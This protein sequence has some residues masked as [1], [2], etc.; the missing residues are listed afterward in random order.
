MPTDVAKLTW[1]ELRELGDAETRIP[2][3]A[4]VL[5]LFAD[6]ASTLLIDMDEAHPAE[7]A[8]RVVAGSGAKVAWCGHLDGMRTIR[9]LDPAARIWMPWDVPGSP[10]AADIAALSPEYVNMEYLTATH[11][12]VED[13]HALGCSVAVWTVDDPLTMR[14]VREM[15][16]DAVTTNQLRLLRQVSTQEQSEGRPPG[17]GTQPE[18]NLD[19]VL[20]IARDLGQWVIDFARSSDPGQI[21]TKKDP[22]DLVTEVDVMVERYVREM[23]GARFPGYGFVGEELGGTPTPGVPCWYLDPVDG[24]TNFANRIPWN[25]FSL[26][27]VLDDTP[28]VGVVADPWRGDLFEAVHGRG[29][30]LNG[31]VLTMSGTRAVGDPLSGRVVC[32]ELAQNRL[33]VAPG[34]P[35]KPSST[36]TTR[37]RLK[38]CS[39]DGKAQP[40]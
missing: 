32:T 8:Y 9:S 6:T 10:T 26:A 7:P 4:D 1:P 38:P 37:A 34:T 21:S 39:D 3:L 11:A 12:M 14:W 28:L 19:A 2:R 25:A 20:G 17:P 16:V 27:L 29:A 35:S 31:R 36:L 13:I 5:D 40:R 23:V 22:A 33:M 15:G 30:K 18:L 24:T